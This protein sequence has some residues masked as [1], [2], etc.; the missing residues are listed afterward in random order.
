[1]VSFL[2]TTNDKVK[3]TTQTLLTKGRRNNNARIRIILI[4]LFVF[5]VVASNLFSTWESASNLK[6]TFK[7]N[8]DGGL[9][10][11]GKIENK[12]AS[13]L[14]GRVNGDGDNDGESENTEDGLVESADAVPAFVS[15]MPS[16]SASC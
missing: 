15:A 10:L 7:F 4:V 11:A 3:R 8:L 5:G 6:T 12:S 14:S 16:S 2:P 1:M 9:I 13:N